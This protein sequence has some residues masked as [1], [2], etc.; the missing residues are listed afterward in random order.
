MQENNG[1]ITKSLE[2]KA[3]EKAQKELV[4]FV[5]ADF[6][7]RRKERVALE[8]QWELNLNFLKGNQH[9]RIGLSGNVEKEEKEYF[10]QSKEVF[11]HISPIME[12]R[13]ARLSRVHPEVSVR[14]K[15]D[16]DEKN[17]ALSKQ[18][19]FGY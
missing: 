12:T 5:K 7:R 15:S 2:Q 14:P 4:A 13:L 8:R 9:C 19:L 18:L 3:K 10:W 1:K 11:N 6:E 17:S 16:D